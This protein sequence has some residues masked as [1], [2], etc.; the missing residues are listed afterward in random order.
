[1]YGCESITAVT[2]PV[3]PDVIAEIEAEQRETMAACASHLAM[4]DEASCVE[5]YTALMPYCKGCLRIP[6]NTVELNLVESAIELATRLVDI[7]DDATCDPPPSIVSDS[8]DLLSFIV[9]LE[10]WVTNEP[11]SISTTGFRKTLMQ[12]ASRLITSEKAGITNDHVMKAV[13]LL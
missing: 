1:L 12:G 11:T 13:D 5:R 10:N 4:V 7:V 2:N 6:N 8:M 3:D 9:Q